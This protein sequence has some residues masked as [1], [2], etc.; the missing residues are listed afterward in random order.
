M[1]VKTLILKNL[2]D[3]F[4][5]HG[6]VEELRRLCGIDEKS[7]AEAI[8]INLGIISGETNGKDET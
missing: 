4:I 1:P 2:G 8:E 3:R 5:P 7:V 6:E